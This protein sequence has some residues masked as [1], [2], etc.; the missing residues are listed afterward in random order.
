NI[1]AKEQLESDGEEEVEEKPSPST[2]EAL[3]ADELSSRFVLSNIE[4][5]SMTIAMSSIYNS[6]RNYFYN[7]IKKRQ[8]K[9]T[10]EDYISD[11]R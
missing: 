11:S 4:N 2:E 6:I 8:T 5:D 1:N 7:K 9:I 10:E 3:K